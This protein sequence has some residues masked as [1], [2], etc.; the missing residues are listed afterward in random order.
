MQAYTVFLSHIFLYGGDYMH[1]KDFRRGKYMDLITFVITVFGIAG[2]LISPSLTVNAAAGGINVCL[3][4][5]VPTLFP[6]FVFSSLFISMGF[7]QKLGRKA[8]GLMRPLFHVGGP[9]ASV[10]ILGLLSGF[11]VGAKTAVSLYKNGSCTKTEAERMLAF[12]N[13]AGPSFILGTVGI[14]IWN[15]TSAG[16]ILWGAQD[17]AS[18]VTGIVFSRIWRNSE[19]DK[20]VPVKR[21]VV[22]Q[23]PSFMKAFTSSV[24]DGAVSIVYICAFI[25]FF[26]VVIA[27]LQGFGIIPAVAKGICSVLPFDSSVVENI[28][29]GIF[30]MTTGLRMVGNAAP[31][32]RNLTI[33]GAILGWAGISVHCQVLTFVYEGGLSS[34]PYICGKLLQTLFSSL[35]TLGLSSI[36]RIKDIGVFG[37]LTKVLQSPAFFSYKYL[38]FSIVAAVVLLCAAGLFIIFLINR[39]NN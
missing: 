30:E 17:I 33:T 6:F 1:I 2:L 4:V 23:H 5:I 25:I 36:F 14:G 20:F 11:P 19:D 34:V 9:C 32:I 7:A 35:L 26:A 13:N 21:D 18:I 29:A 16:W 27:M 3:N 37:N 38:L 8:E 12:C 10:F 28:L 24:K 31:V 22:Q 15:S 39:K